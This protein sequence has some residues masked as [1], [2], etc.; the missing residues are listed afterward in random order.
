MKLMTLIIIQGLKKMYL[1]QYHHR[2]NTRK[3]DIKISRLW[4]WEKNGCH[5]RCKL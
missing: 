1:S 4:N 2:K 5:L 3:C